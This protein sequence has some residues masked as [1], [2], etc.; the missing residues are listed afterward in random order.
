MDQKELSPG[1]RLNRIKTQ[2]M[3]LES[4]TTYS[5]KEQEDFK[6]ATELCISAILQCQ[7]RSPPVTDESQQYEFFMKVW[8]SRFKKAP[9]DASRLNK[10]DAKRI[11]YRRARKQGQR[12]T[13][14]TCPIVSTGRRNFWTYKTSTCEQ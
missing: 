5:V 7:A 6:S 13:S 12:E 10:S 3:G 2:C 8:Y 11:F 1:K 14:K 4:D 9:A